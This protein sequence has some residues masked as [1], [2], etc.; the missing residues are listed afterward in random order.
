M[1]PSHSRP[2]TRQGPRCLPTDGR[3]LRS[4]PFNQ[5]GLTVLPA[6]QHLSTESGYQQGPAGRKGRFQPVGQSQGEVTGP[7]SF[8]SLQRS[9]TLAPRSTRLPVTACSSPPRSRSLDRG[10]PQSSRGSRPG[11]RAQCH[12]EMVGP[13]GRE[14]RH[15]G[16]VLKGDSTG[17]PLPTLPP[18]TL[19]RTGLFR[20]LPTITHSATKRPKHGI[21]GLWTEL[22]ETVH[23][24]TP[25]LFFK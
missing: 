14:A 18:A 17:S 9:S 21:K 16:C 23:Q 19:R 1:L 13:R 8:P 20:S 2:L 10:C 3:G 12:W 4:P 11:A 6:P 15:W 7:E 22:S 25:F 5:G 24:N